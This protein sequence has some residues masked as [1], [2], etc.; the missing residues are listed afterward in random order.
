MSFRYTHRPGEIYRKTYALRMHRSLVAAMVIVLA[1]LFVARFITLRSVGLSEV[2]LTQLEALQV[3]II[4]RK[5]L[6]ETKILPPV[7]K[8]EPETSVPEEISTPIVAVP[9]KNLRRNSESAK[10]NLSDVN[11]DLFDQSALNEFDRLAAAR[12]R[13]S[14]FDAAADFRTDLNVGRLDVGPASIDLGIDGVTAKRKP[15]AGITGP[16][17]SLEEKTMVR[18][19]QQ[20][21]PVEKIDEDLLQAD[22]SV[23]LTSNDVNIDI[24]EYPLWNRINAEFDR[25][26]KGRYGALHRLLKK[27]GRSII[28]TLGFADGTSQKIIW[29]RGSTKILVQ[30][31]SN[32]NRIDELR[33]AISAL[34]R[35]NLN[36][37]RS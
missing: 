36:Q 4:K 26:D 27:R 15:A 22:I 25:W 16:K 10:L 24:N 3:E 34:T 5:E 33:Q 8:I 11:V 7:Q 6:P 29:N 14:A 32:R 17:V 12:G 21:A 20:K 9:E 19:A 35:L 1:L 30:G 13:N 23:V 2:K 18:P 28:A 31:R 37:T